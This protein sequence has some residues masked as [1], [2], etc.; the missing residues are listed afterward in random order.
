[1]TVKGTLFA[2][3]T[4]V[5]TGS[6]SGIGRATARAFGE[7]GASVMLNGRN[8]EK[9]RRT[10]EELRAMGLVVDY[11]IADVQ[12]YEECRTLV[13]RT[14]ERFGRID[15]VIAN[16]S[17]S[18]RAEF[19]R[20]DPAVFRHVLDSNLL[21]AA[22]TAHAALPALAQTRGSLLLIGSLAGLLG[23][24]TG[25]AYSAGKMALTALAQSLRIEVETLGVH[26]GIAYVGFTRNDPEKRVFD[27]EGRLVPVAPRKSW[28]QQTQEQV[29]RSLVRMAYRRKPRLVLSP[30]GKLL[31]TL[32]ALSPTLAERGV[33]WS[34]RRFPRF[35]QDE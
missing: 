4:V 27:A 29:A 16:A 14:V 17:S 34:Y 23:L 19:M 31:W 9:L 1:M 15:V 11:C 12:H 8:E 20:T 30:L 2:N 33:R 13:E 18:Q 25:S 10:C 35:Y 22:Y 6:G 7:A 5:V 21:S 24:P 3:K 28:M 32:N 26:V